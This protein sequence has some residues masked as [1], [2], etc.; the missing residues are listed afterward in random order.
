MRTIRTAYQSIAS[1]DEQ[2]YKYVR[3]ALDKVSSSVLECFPP[4]AET[5]W[6]EVE[7]IFPTPRLPGIPPDPSLAHIAKTLV[8]YL[9]P[10]Q[11]VSPA[12]SSVPAHSNEKSFE[13][14]LRYVP[15][16]YNEETK[17]ALLFWNDVANYLQQHQK[18]E[19][20]SLLS[21]FITYETFKVHQSDILRT[22]DLYAPE[23]ERESTAWKLFTHWK[24]NN[25]MKLALGR[26][27]DVQNK[28]VQNEFTKGLQQPLFENRLEWW[29]VMVEG[30]RRKGSVKAWIWV[31]NLMVTRTRNEI[32]PNITQLVHQIPASSSTT[33]S[34]QYLDR[35]TVE[36]SRTLAKLYMQWLEQSYSAV[37]TV[38]PVINFVTAI[39]NQ[40]ISR[41]ISSPSHPLFVLGVE[42]HW[43]RAVR[44]YGSAKAFANLDLPLSEPRYDT[45]DPKELDLEEERC[46]LR[47]LER[48]K[49]VSLTQTMGWTADASMFWGLTR[50]REGG[51]DDFVNMVLGI[52]STPL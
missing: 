20:W 41:L 47:V 24:A 6:D 46:R 31:L 8:K 44:E 12:F 13:V 29:K 27:L 10:R 35:A 1:S 2:L 28:D 49:E 18:F 51:E 23:S 25:A 48:A 32:L 33:I 37:Q 9:R 45:S 17:S 42:V 19:V 16:F 34:R 4:L 21:P 5:M 26:F 43:S 14:L 15:P 50:I 38:W 36:E 40:C 52:L 22:F 30:A 7:D 39:A 3:D 11:D